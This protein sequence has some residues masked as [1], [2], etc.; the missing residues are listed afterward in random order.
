MSG[1]VRFPRSFPAAVAILTA[2]VIVV[3]MALAAWAGDFSRPAIAMVMLIFGGLFLLVGAMIS[4]GLPLLGSLQ[5]SD[6]GLNYANTM[7]TDMLLQQSL[8]DPELLR[9]A[10]RRRRVGVR[11]LASG[12][13]LV[14]I[15]LVV[16]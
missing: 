11:L 9:R 2:V 6:Q 14:V 7:H 16:G 13:L 4:G 15:G 1:H 5:G 10:N 8:R 12:A 3:A